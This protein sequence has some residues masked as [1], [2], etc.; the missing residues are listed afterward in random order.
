MKKMQHRKI[1]DNILNYV[2]NFFNE[3][4]HF[5]EP[6]EDFKTVSAKFKKIWHWF[7]I[8]LNNFVELITAIFYIVFPIP[9]FLD[10]YHVEKLQSNDIL[11]A[12]FF[13]IIIILSFL[14]LFFFYF[15]NT[16]PARISVLYLIIGLTFNSYYQPEKFD[17]KDYYLLLKKI[18]IEIKKKNIPKKGDSSHFVLANNNMH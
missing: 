10:F 17:W 4:E 13:S 6:N 12:L 2:E 8:F 3:D 16:I 1:I 11:F 7:Y 18:N 5:A 14:L 15:H 9:F